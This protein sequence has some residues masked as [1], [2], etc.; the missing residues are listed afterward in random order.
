MKIK[1]FSLLVA[2]TML[3]GTASAEL[4]GVA[5]GNPLF[6]YNS[7]GTTVFDAGTGAITVNATPFQYNQPDGTVL[8]IFPLG[9]NA[10]VTMN[11]SLD[12]SCNLV[13]GDDGGNDLTVMADIDV[14]PYDFVPEFTG[15]L[16]TGE[17]LELGMDPVISSSSIV[18]DARFAITGGALVTGGDYTVGA[19]V[20]MTL[21]V[22]GNNF[23]SCAD[24]WNGGAKGDIG[25]IESVPPEEACFDVKKIKI[26]DGKKHWRHWGSYGH[27]KSKISAMLNTSCPSGFDPNASVVSLMLDGETFDFPIGSFNQVG[28]SNKYRAWV[29]G[30]PSLRA[31]LNCDKGRFSFSASKADT[32]QIDNSD[33]VDVTL[34]LGSQSSS[35]NV[36]LM[37]SGHHYYGHNNV[38]YYHNSN[39]TSCAVDNGDDDSHMHEFKVRHKHSGRIY[40][41]KRSR[42]GYGKTCMVYDANS[43]H[44]SSFDTSTTSSVTC[45]SGDSNFEV[46]GIE[47]KNNSM[48]CASLSEEEEDDDVESNEH[49]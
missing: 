5:P 35:K 42:G 45:G 20:G 44:Y 18:F 41:F 22:E 15:T 39:P 14:Q 13:G 21:V 25:A 28:S 10:S 2:T 19:E 3:S 47:H 23:A 36:S 4:I 48:S 9:T 38:M 37:S 33:G 17:I 12:Q 29:G 34:V 30:S 6:K 27:S 1:T 40:S 46:V 16:L 31:T 49:D 43:G 11:A 24:S 26:R 32:S 8:D 7:G